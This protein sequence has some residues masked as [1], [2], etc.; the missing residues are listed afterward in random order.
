MK[1][2]RSIPKTM[3]VVAGSDGDIG[4]AVVSAF[5]SAGF[6]VTGLSRAERRTKKLDR[7]IRVDLSDITA[8]RQAAKEIFSS[9]GSIP[10]VV[11]AA[12]GFRRTFQNAVDDEVF[13][14][15][16]VVAENILK[17]FSE[18][19]KTV[20]NARI[21]TIGSW[22]GIYPNINSFSYSVTK[23]AIRTLV[24][25][26]Q[27]TFRDSPLNFDLLL[28][29]AVNTRMRKDKPEDKTALIQAE[30]IAKV[31]VCLGTLNSSAAIEEIVI[32]PKSGSY[33]SYRPW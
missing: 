9:A 2:A 22:D 4:Q 31:C 29:G 26:Y 23:S 13:R 24:R 18:K 30:D 6:R 17:V 1:R 15:N 12:G 32:Y 8:V 25:L 28:P 33:P 10:L 21:I 5:S 7:S 16:F 19:M 27:K 14:N 11:N 20:R 3:V